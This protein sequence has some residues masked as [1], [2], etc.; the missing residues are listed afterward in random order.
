MKR[1][2][3]D[4]ERRAA[5]EERV[6]AAT[7]QLLADGVRYDDLGIARIAA[8]AGIARSTFYLYFTDKPELINRLGARLKQELFD[9]AADWTPADGMTGLAA[10]YE[11]MISHYRPRTAL[12]AAINQVAANDP[13][14]RA[15]WQSTVDMFT[16]RLADA[17][18]D[19]QR[20]G[21]TPA[22]LDPLLTAQVLTWG[23]EQVIARQAASGDPARDAAVAR[24][25]AI[26]RWFGAFR[27]PPL[28]TSPDI[29]A[30]P[31]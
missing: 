31:R 5:V 1:A 6:L 8:A 23:G 15:A 18:A 19:E 3:P 29:A 27:R 4:P 20:A 10:V 17:L 7:E 2:H 13:A 26:N 22:D 25:M 14:V 28:P 12:L 16:H 21:R 11:R 24:E 30:S 9:L